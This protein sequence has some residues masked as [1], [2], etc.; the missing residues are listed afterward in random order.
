MSK[1]PWHRLYHTKRWERIRRLQL[2]K[3]PLCRM[4]KANGIVREANV[5]DHIVPHRGDPKLFWF[6]ELQSLCPGCHDVGKR[7]VERTGYSKEIGADGYPV[8]PRHPVNRPGQQKGGGG[9]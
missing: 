8:D 7:Q 6:G 3:E 1:Q 4:C 2:Q 5:A 9:S